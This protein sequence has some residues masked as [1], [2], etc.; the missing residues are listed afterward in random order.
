MATGSRTHAHEQ[1]LFCRRIH[2]CSHCRG[3]HAHSADHSPHAALHHA[4]R[5]RHGGQGSGGWHPA[6]DPLPSHFTLSSPRVEVA[7]RHH[8]FH[9][10]CDRFGEHGT[11]FCTA[12]VPMERHV[13]LRPANHL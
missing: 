13:Y 10:P 8:F 5:R 1:R 9:S 6:H 12:L 7:F 2:L 11:F 3:P 4:H